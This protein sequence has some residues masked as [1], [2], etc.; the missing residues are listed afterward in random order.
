MRLE[1]RNQRPKRAMMKMNRYKTKQN[2]NCPNRRTM[3]SARIQENDNKSYLILEEDNDDNIMKNI[4]RD[5]NKEQEFI[6]DDKDN[7]NNKN[8]FNYLK[9][10]D[11]VSNDYE[12]NDTASND[13][14]E[15]GTRSDFNYS[16]DSDIVSNNCEAVGTRSDFYYRS[17][18]DTVSNNCEEVGTRS[19][20]NYLSGNDTL[21]NDCEI[22]IKQDL[23]NNSKNILNQKELEKKNTMKIVTQNIRG[24]SSDKKKADFGR[25]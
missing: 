10:N 21:R 24:I 12:I 2:T 25:N 4:N 14:E 20:F 13:C 23:E 7:N 9:E 17:D 18:S 8:F 11:I 15:V 6:K 19:D 5:I 3:D 16:S 1:Q 22:N